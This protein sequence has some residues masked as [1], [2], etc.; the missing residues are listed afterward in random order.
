MSRVTSCLLYTSHGGEVLVL[1]DDAFVVA[2]EDDVF[3][4]KARLGHQAEHAAAE[5]VSYTHLS[6]HQAAAARLGGLDMRL[7]AHGD[8]TA[9]GLVGLSLIH[10]STIDSNAKTYIITCLP[11]SSCA[12]VLAPSSPYRSAF[13]SGV[14]G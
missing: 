8:G 5:A 3:H 4:L 14:Y 10:I 1:L 11:V 2:L 13:P 12:E 9:A 7:G 6:E